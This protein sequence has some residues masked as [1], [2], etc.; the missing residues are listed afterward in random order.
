MGL[1]LKN[2]VLYLGAMET[3]DGC[4]VLIERSI[5]VLILVFWMLGCASAW[6]LAQATVVFASPEGI[7]VFPFGIS[8]PDFGTDPILPLWSG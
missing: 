8:F 4:Q 6:L 3:Q 7:P 5:M 2:R 1:H